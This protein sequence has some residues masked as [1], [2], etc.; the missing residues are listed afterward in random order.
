MHPASISL[1]LNTTRAPRFS[2]ALGAF[3][4]RGDFRLRMPHKKKFSTKTRSHCDKI[5]QNDEK[6]KRRPQ[7]LRFL[8]QNRLVV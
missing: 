6:K 7:S 8:R 4:T 2:R 1:A 3:D 5:S